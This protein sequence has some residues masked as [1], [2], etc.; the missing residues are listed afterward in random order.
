[1]SCFCI[2]HR[3]RL[4]ASRPSCICIRTVSRILASSINITHVLTQCKMKSSTQG[5]RSRQGPDVHTFFLSCSAFLMRKG[6]GSCDSGLSVVTEKIA[7][8]GLTWVRRHVTRP[9]AW[10]T[11]QKQTRRTFLTDRRPYDHRQHRRTTR[12]RIACC[13]LAM[14]AWGRLCSGGRTGYA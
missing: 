3:L 10:T 13:S 4:L 1:M 11:A 2:S 7:S 9:D 14:R 5:L 6:A 8:S 12:G